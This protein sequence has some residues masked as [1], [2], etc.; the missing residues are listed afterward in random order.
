MNF[1]IITNLLL[2]LY[3]IN[4]N[5]YFYLMTSFKSGK[6]ISFFKELNSKR[7][8]TF[9]FMKF[10]ETFIQ[11]A[12]FIFIFIGLAFLIRSIWW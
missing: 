9:R 5:I 8:D 12:S 7:I 11:K 10:Y 2:I 3:A 4:I 1:Q 6:Q